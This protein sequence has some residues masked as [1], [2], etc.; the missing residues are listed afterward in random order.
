MT[1]KDAAAQFYEEN[2]AWHQTHD[3]ALDVDEVLRRLAL[4]YGRYSQAWQFLLANPGLTV[5]ELGCGE[6]ALP[7]A[8]ATACAHYT[9]ID[10]VE[11]RLGS[12]V[13]DNVRAICANLDNDFPVDDAGYDV[14]VAMMVV[15]HL[16]NPF[17]SFAQIARVLKPGGR[18]YVNLPNIASLR[19]R[20][21]LLLGRL[22]NTSSPDSFDR[23]EWDGNH[24]HYF[25]VASVKR[26]AR[27]CGL[28]VTAL[29]PVGKGV[30]IKRL[31]P[32]LLAHEITY[33]IEK[34]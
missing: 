19:C 11:A 6:P 12:A 5:L 14:V 21:D 18:A 25:T 33:V 16:F 7:L 8:F 9:V 15:E 29:H 27:H 28:A 13:P 3:Q 22:P 30:A 26:L 24:L 34:P 2:F 23:G 17:H 10:I 20:I 31:R 4:P 32:H 1:T